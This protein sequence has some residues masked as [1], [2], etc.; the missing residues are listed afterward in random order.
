[1]RATLL[2]LL[3]AFPGAALAQSTDS[4]SIAATSLRLACYDKAAPPATHPK[5][6]APAQPER[7][8]DQLAIENERV[9]AKTK[10]ICRGC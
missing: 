7:F 8:I 2:F 3:F 9:N 5:P 6:A 10:T 4:K 1:M